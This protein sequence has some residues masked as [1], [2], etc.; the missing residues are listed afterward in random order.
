MRGKG[1]CD[2]AVARDLNCG[3]HELCNPNS[4]P[5]LPI[6]RQNHCAEADSHA[7]SVLMMYAGAR[8]G[9][10]PCVYLECSILISN[11]VL[12]S[13]KESGE[14]SLTRGSWMTPALSGVGSRHNTSS[15]TCQ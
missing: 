8:G 5:G 12:M 3:C 7:S 1:R 4:I 13:C 14:H 2:V 15:F 6:S 11:R 10:I 9:D